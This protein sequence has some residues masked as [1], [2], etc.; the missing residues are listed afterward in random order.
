MQYLKYIPL[1]VLAV[2]LQS[3]GTTLDEDAMLER[4]KMEALYPENFDEEVDA[5]VRKLMNREKVTVE[6]VKERLGE[7]DY[8]MNPNNQGQIKEALADAWYVESAAVAGVSP[9]DLKVLFWHPAL[10]AH[11]PHW[12]N[13]VKQKPSVLGQPYSVPAPGVTLLTDGK[14]VWDFARGTLSGPVDTELLGSVV[15]EPPFMDA[16]LQPDSR[17]RADEDQLEVEVEARAK[18]RLACERPL[19]RLSLMAPGAD[20]FRH[21]FEQIILHEDWKLIDV[22]QERR[23]EMYLPLPPEVADMSGEW[24]ILTG[25]IY[26]F[27]QADNEERVATAKP[28]VLAPQ[29]IFVR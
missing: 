17:I 8:V 20:G 3:C 24:L 6:D 27:E 21:E 12:T 11:E 22:G 13:W 25:T 16:W 4:Q 5:V 19:L 28:V 9:M 15:A 1:L 18:S 7:P 29:Q 23:Q 26:L 10:R 14:R 2:A